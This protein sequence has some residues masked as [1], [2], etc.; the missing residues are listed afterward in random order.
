MI[1]RL[2]TTRYLL[3]DLVSMLRSLAEGVSDN[4]WRFFLQSGCSNL[5]ELGNGHYIFAHVSVKNTQTSG[6][7][8]LR[9]RAAHMS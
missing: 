8:H 6:K 7:T 5:L 3:W 2:R 1:T 4:L 9:I